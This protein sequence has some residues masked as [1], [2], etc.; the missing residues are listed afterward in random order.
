MKIKNL[1]GST[2]QLTY[3]YT[4]MQFIMDKVF[5][6]LTSQETKPLILLEYIKV[7]QFWKLSISLHILLFKIHK[8]VIFLIN[9]GN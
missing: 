4:Q 5:L 7:F 8:D 6:L 3:L 9:F 1:N 2:K